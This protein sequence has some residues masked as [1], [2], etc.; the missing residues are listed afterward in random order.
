MTAAHT[1]PLPLPSDSPRSVRLIAAAFA[2]AVGAM[3]TMALRGYQFGQSNHT[4]YLLDAIHTLHP[5]LLNRDWYVTHTLQYH[6][7]FGAMSR[8]LMAAGIE[9]AGF[10]LAHLL[11]VVGLHIAWL[12][13]VRRLGGSVSAYLLS[14]LLFYLSAGGTGLGSF[15]FIQDG[16]FL[17]S[18]LANVAMLW[19]IWLWMR[20]DRGWAGLA[21]GVGALWH[22]NHAAVG[23]GLWVTL[24]AW[25][26]WQAVG[27]R[28]RWTQAQLLGGAALLLLSLVNLIPAVLAKMAPSPDPVSLHEFVRLYV[29]LRHPH[30]NGPRTWPPA[31]W[32]SFLWSTPLA[33]LAGRRALRT[34]RDDAQR[35]AWIESARVFAIL[36]ALLIVGLL[37]AGIWFVNETLIQIVVYR[38]TIYLQLL[39]CAATAW[40]ILDSGAFR[41]GAAVGWIIVAATG[42]ALATLQFGTF[43][44]SQLA[45]AAQ[46]VHENHAPLA[47]FSLAAI[48]V[49]L[50]GGGR[51]LLATPVGTALHALG[52][53]IVCAIIGVGWGRWLGLNLI[54]TDDP[55]YVE[56][57]HWVRDHTPTDAL[58][59]VPPDEQSFRLEARRAIY[60]NFKGVAQLRGEIGI[61]R[62]RLREVLDLDDL[63]TLPQPFDQTLK[64]IGQRYESL[65]AAHLIAVA[66][67]N[68]IRYILIAHPLSDPDAGELI[69]RSSGG[70]Y[71]LY[72]LHP[73]NGAH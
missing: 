18:N 25:D 13:I 3:M 5:D 38:F 63:W 51:R 64:A 21:L 43:S 58:F 7:I 66:R 31:V 16:A 40:W 61:W 73:R 69:H 44:N 65:P 56:M 2:I 39:A 55:Q 33:L 71:F 68:D 20:G 4:V 49:A 45:R 26:A 50:H 14:V 70:K 17:P 28:R 42:I 37:G 60:I 67:K 19:G 9:H 11:T 41:R 15:Q 27:G 72:D 32:I 12:G 8:W 22:V 10:L 6:I 34:I 23:I 62:D 36:W 24:S 35:L 46:A 47:V 30:H 48:I 54:P 29:Y 53:V 52:L 1:T 59:M 57:T